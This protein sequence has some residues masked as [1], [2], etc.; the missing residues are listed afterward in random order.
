MEVT[1]SNFAGT[2]RG[3]YIG[4]LDKKYQSGRPGT[5]PG[6]TGHIATPKNAF[7]TMREKNMGDIGAK[8]L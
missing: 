7:Q 3:N 8:N 4:L 1:S 2:L 6:A 5:K